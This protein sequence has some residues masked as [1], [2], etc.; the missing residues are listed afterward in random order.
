MPKVSFIIPVY[1]AEK[2][3][4]KCLESIISLSFK[5]WEVIIVDDGS[6]DSSAEI[7]DHYAE[8]DSRIKVFHKCNGGVSSARNLGL[9]EVSG[10]YVTFVDFIRALQFN[11]TAPTRS[12]FLQLPSI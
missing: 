2:C 3:V 12:T 10:E 4:S 6:K 11:C 9:S 7:C 8:K 5:D 1:N